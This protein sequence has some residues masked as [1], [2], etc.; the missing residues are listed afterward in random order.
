MAAGWTLALL[1]LGL[2]G[3]ALVGVDP[4]AL[5][6]VHSAQRHPLS[7]AVVVALAF[8]AGVA[9]SQV[10]RRTLLAFVAAPACES[11]A[12]QSRAGRRAP[13]RPSLLPCGRRALARRPQEGA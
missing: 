8:A 7:A 3:L 4:P 10:I 6:V 5:D 12:G 9:S 13:G 11:G 2:A 1:A